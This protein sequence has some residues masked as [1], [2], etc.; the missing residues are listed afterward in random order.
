[1]RDSAKSL[2]ARRLVY[3]ISQLNLLGYISDFEISLVTW[4]DDSQVVQW[5]TGSELPAKLLNCQGSTRA[6]PLIKL[7]GVSERD[8]YMFLTDGY[9]PETAR[10]AIRKW[11]AQLPST[12]VRVIRIGADANPEFVGPEVFEAEDLFFAIDDWWGSDIALYMV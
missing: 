6:A 2:I 4:A 3:Q 12:S 9:W 10:K 5:S 8:R 7:L 1:M 11:R